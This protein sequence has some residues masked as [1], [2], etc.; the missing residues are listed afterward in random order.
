MK[1]KNR[2]KKSPVCPY[3]GSPTVLRP[4]S[5]VYKNDPRGRYL[6]VCARYPDC[7]AYV[8]ADEN[9][10]EPLGIPANGDLRHKRIEAHRVFDQIWRSRI[11][12]RANAYR[13]LREKYGMRKDQAH[14]AKF[15]DYICED[16]IQ[17]CQKALKANRVAS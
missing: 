4:D 7:D 1:Q 17:E 12:T 15:S 8:S 5:Y 6:Y 11:M 3:C 14:I 10:L 16:L 13:W 2:R 9:T